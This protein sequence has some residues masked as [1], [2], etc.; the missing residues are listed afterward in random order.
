VGDLR[1]RGAPQPLGHEWRYGDSVTGDGLADEAG[2][3][4]ARHQVGDGM[5]V[6]HRLGGLLQLT[7]LQIVWLA[8]APCDEVSFA[9]VAG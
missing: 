5:S 6:L 1:Q 7:Q 2:H 3:A 8:D 4:V 9:A